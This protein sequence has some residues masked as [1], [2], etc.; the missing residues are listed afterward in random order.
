V[1]VSY[2]ILLGFGL[3]LKPLPIGQASHVTTHP[4]ID[5]ASASR[6]PS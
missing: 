4:F 5:R 2:G 1:Q 6:P 3:S